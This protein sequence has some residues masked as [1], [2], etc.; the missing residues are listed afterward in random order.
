MSRE[1]DE[2]YIEAKWKL[3]MQL[4]EATSKL[5]EMVRNWS[6]EL[7]KKHRLLAEQQ[8]RVREAYEA[9]QEKDQKLEESERKYRAIVESAGDAIISLDAENTVLSW[10]EGAHEVFGYSQDE[11]IGKNIDELLIKEDIRDEALQLTRK[12]HGGEKIMTFESVRYAKDGRPKNVL[13]T[14]TP[15]KDPQGRTYA[16]SL[17]Y[18][19]ITQLKIAQQRLI[20]SEKQAAL[21]LIAGSIGHEL[22]NAVGEMLIYANLLKKNPEDVEQVKE[23]ID[24][25][26]EIVERCSIH[27]RDLLSLSRPA[28]PEMKTL[29]LETILEDTTQ[30]MV[31][32]GL[33]KRFTIVRDYTPNLPSVLGDRN[34]IEQ[35]I[36]NLEINGA[37]A[38]GDEGT[39][40]IGTRCSKDG[41]FVEF[42]IKDTGH[43]MSQEIREKIFEP[44][45]TTKCD[46]AGTGLGMHVVKGIVEQHKGYIRIESEVGKGTTMIVGIPT[47]KR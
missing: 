10:N 6:D 13:I 24:T 14:A 12:A 4:Q 20:Q 43:G 3:E 31:T 47:R 11:A 44:F 33:L 37:H 21:G 1:R 34:Q 25:I 32:C 41:Q 28:E 26:G 5:E 15:L 16:I 30:T 17:I 9:L 46:G 29:S 7:L 19:D 2:E 8:E 40:T 39:L 23:L 22:N 45:Y 42:L 35:I 38:M 36:R 18:K 27:S